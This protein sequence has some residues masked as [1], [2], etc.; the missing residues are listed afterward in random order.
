[1]VKPKAS[2]KGLDREFCYP[3][4]CAKLCNIDAW[5]MNLNIIW[6]YMI[7]LNYTSFMVSYAHHCGICYM[8]LTFNTIYSELFW[9]VRTLTCW[10]FKTT[11]P[12]FNEIH[13]V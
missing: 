3:V 11:E 12:V 7:V 13:R 6:Y 5:L 1:M 8:I 10:Y 2:W 4:T 9:D